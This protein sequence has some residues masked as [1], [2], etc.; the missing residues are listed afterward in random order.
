MPLEGCVERQELEHLWATRVRDARLRLAFARN[1]AKDL[2]GVDPSPDGQQAYWMALH[3]ERV[4][5]AEYDRVLR[6]FTDLV[7][8]GK[9]PDEDGWRKT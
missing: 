8:E 7:M 6:I 3:A 5:L 1:Y 9:I 4:A 2:E